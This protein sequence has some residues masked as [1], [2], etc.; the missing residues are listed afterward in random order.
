M[1]FDAEKELEY[2]MIENYDAFCKII[3]EERKRKK[4]IQAEI[5]KRL[6]VTQAYYCQMESGKRNIDFEVARR[7]C[8]IL[9][10]ELEIN[11]QGYNCPG[12]T[13]SVADELSGNGVKKKDSMPFAEMVADKL[14]SE[15]K[16]EGKSVSIYLTTEALENLEKFAKTNGCSKSKAADLILRNLY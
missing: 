11:P 14:K 2:M 15:K 12:E 6:N 8:N 13:D 9:E 10:I 16:I 3:K 4:M 1:C 5:A 7:I